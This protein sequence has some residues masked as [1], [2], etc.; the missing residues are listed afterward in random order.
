VYKATFIFL[1]F[2][3]AVVIVVVGALLFAMQAF[4]TGETPSRSVA[5]GSIYM[6]A[7]L[8]TIIVQIAIIFPGI[9]L[10]QPS[11]LWNVVRAEKQAITPRQRFRG[12]HVIS[13]DVNMH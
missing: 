6:A 9:L 12:E 5:N 4:S 1:T 3:T 13:Y 8:L 2:I 7:L 10:L 11:R